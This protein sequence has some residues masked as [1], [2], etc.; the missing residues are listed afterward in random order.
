MGTPRQASHLKRQ[1]HPPGQLLKLGN[2]R[3]PAS[4]PLA[5][6]ITT[7]AIPTYPKH[8]ESVPRPLSSWPPASLRSLRWSPHQAP[9]LHPRQNMPGMHIRPLWKLSQDFM[10]AGLQIP[11]CGLPL[12]S[13]WS[14]PA[15]ARL[16]LRFHAPLP[17]PSAPTVSSLF[18]RPRPLFPPQ[19][20]AHAVPSA[21]TPFPASLPPSTLSANPLI[22]AKVSAPSRGADSSAHRAPTPLV[23]YHCSHAFLSFLKG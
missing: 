15:Q 14:T 13:V 8:P 1:H 2:A 19:S 23:P 22:S 20:P 7:P 4:Q 18:P 9:R 21:V 5:Q 11:S 3:Q 12:N 16:C 17:H 10:I 6:P